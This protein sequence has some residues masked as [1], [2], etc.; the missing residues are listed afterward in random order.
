LRNILSNLDQHQTI[1]DTN[2]EL[3]D[4][5]S[6]LFN[7]DSLISDFDNNESTYSQSHYSLFSTILTNNESTYLDKTLTD[8][9]NGSLTS[10]QSSLSSESVN[11]DDFT[12][13]NCHTDYSSNTWLI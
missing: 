2:N 4:F 9:S 1:H 10:Y 11:S 7:S 12:L 13:T 6:E 3:D 8:G 5:K